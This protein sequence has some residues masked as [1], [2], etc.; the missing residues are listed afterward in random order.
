MLLA[1]GPY[2]L[3]VVIEAFH[4]NCA[5]AIAS[6]KSYPIWENLPTHFGQPPGGFLA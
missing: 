3:V 4:V 6:L 2:R 5:S 1:V